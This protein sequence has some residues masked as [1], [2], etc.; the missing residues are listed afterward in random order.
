MQDSNLVTFSLNN[1]NQRISLNRQMGKIS[2]FILVPTV[3]FGAVILLYLLFANTILKNAAENGLGDS[4]GAEVNIDDLDHS[5]MPFGISIKRMQATDPSAP[6]RNKFEI[7]SLAADVDLMPLLGGKVIVEN[8]IV[9]DVAFGTTRQAPGEVYRKAEK[10][11]NFAFPTLEDLPSVDEV[12]ENTP[13]KTTA[14]ISNAKTVY[15]K[16]EVP[17][18]SRYEALPDE[19]KL[20]AYKAQ[21]KALQDTDVKD[22]ASLANALQS[23]KSL[24]ENISAD[25]GKIS[26]FVALAQEA[27]HETADSVDTLKSAPQ[28]DYNLLKGL[29]G[30]DQAAIDQVS[31]HLFGDKAELYVK[32][33]LAM[34]ELA[35]GDDSQAV[36]K[37]EAID[38]SGLPS[39]W[40]KNAKISVNWLD[41]SI[42]SEWKNITS[43]HSLIQS[44]TTFVVKSAKANNWKTIDING[45]FEMINSALTS[46]QSWNIAGLTMKDIAL[47][48]DNAA[49]KLTASINSGLLNSSGKLS[50]NNN[51]L[52]GQSEFLLSKLA[53]Q[54]S[55][56]NDLTTAIADIVKQ[57]DAINLTSD[58]TGSVFNPSV[59]LSSDLD[60]QLLS[61]LGDNIKNNPKLNELK[62]KL[63]AKANAQLGTSGD[64]LENINALLVAAEGDSNALSELLN[65]QLADP[66]QKAIDKL[67]DKL[68]N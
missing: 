32:A 12:L 25:K 4:L 58:I 65:A 10:P 63:N 37:E 54:A 67:K 40:I 15:E 33:L 62:Q 5:L 53:M 6:I 38:D 16:Y 47:I 14:A 29:V 59:S 1:R 42:A 27:K 17:L 43:Q 49:Q 23:L 52:M 61:A 24:K 13:L 41:E 31:Q 50:I 20:N 68:F 56:T 30:G 35:A 46:T 3:L 48:P 21:V 55:G 7:A 22:P 28:E 8:L 44:P 26:E 9:D 66:K 39:L 64:Q 18:K 11:S 34:T 60:K 57:Q 36:E 51:Q 19:E 45:T 2:L